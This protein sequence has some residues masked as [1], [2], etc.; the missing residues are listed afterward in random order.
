MNNSKD[1]YL[2]RYQELLKL[3]QEKDTCTIIAD[4]M[5]MVKALK[6]NQYAMI[7]LYDE[8]YYGNV[9]VQVLGNF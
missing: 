2:Y 6:L 9:P 8:Q 1:M 7:M 5:M 3:V 4:G